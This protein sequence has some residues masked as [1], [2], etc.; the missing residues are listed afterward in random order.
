M[1]RIDHYWDGRNLVAFTLLPLSWLFCL[2]AW[3]RRQ[4]Y[5]GGLLRSA[6]LPVPVIV[7]GNITVG[8]TGKTP[9]TVWLC[10]HARGLGY[11]PG[12]LIRGYGGKARDWPRSVYPDSDPAEVGDEAVLLAR[13]TG[14]P[15]MAGAK[16][17]DSGLRLL[18]ETDCDLLIADDGL[19]H[20]GLRRDLE[21]AVIDTVR[22]L[23]NG[24]CLPAGPLRERESRLKSVDLVLYNGSAPGAGMGMQLQAEHALRLRDPE[25]VR[26]LESFRNIR[27]TAVAG[28]GN[29][30]RFFGL[31]RGLGI[32]VTERAYPDHH[33]FQAADLERREGIALLMTEKDAVKCTAWADTDCW[34]V[35]VRAVPD[36]RFVRRLDQLLEG[37]KR[38]G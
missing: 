10:R 2:V 28:I 22:G 5:R 18:Q 12:I 24:F 32:E 26:P 21:I 38:D 1:Q 17:V 13:R 4:A 20:Y 19:Q 29:P 15:V 11:K 16:R 25:D 36:E 27:V 14:A 31:L 3:L 9:L 33:A 37:L 34:Y 6:R 7:V 30:G 35:P 8:G 23:G